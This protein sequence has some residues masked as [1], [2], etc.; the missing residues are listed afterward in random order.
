MWIFGIH[1]IRFVK[2]F[3]LGGIV[4]PYSP[5]KW[6]IPKSWRVAMVLQLR[7]GP[8]IDP[9]KIEK[10]MP[11]KSWPSSRVYARKK[12][13]LFK[14]FASFC[15]SWLFSVKKC[16][17]FTRLLFQHS[18]WWKLLLTTVVP[19]WD[20]LDATM[21]AMQVFETLDVNELV[22]SNMTATQDLIRDH[23]IMFQHLASWRSCEYHIAQFHDKM[24][25]FKSTLSGTFQES[26]TNYNDV[27]R[28]HPKWWFNK[29]TSPKS[30]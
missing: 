29:G 10:T 8:Y 25:F 6:F 1:H 26:H 30:P 2:P 19:I 7:R 14:R 5:T 18:P 24:C 22:Q 4:D 21:Q 27:S 28:R 17:I 13:G 3:F 12:H 15:F 20:V 9:P 23:V 16:F 11:W